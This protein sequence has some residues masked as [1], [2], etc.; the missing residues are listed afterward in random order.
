MVILAALT[1]M[2]AGRD[3]RILYLAQ[4]WLRYPA[5]RC[6]FGQEFLHPGRSPEQHDA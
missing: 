2:S 1:V 5:Q 3:A 6:N 4:L